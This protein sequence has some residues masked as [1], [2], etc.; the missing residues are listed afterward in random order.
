MHVVVILS[1]QFEEVL[2]K[3]FD[4]SEYFCHNLRFL[5][6]SKFLAEFLTDF[7]IKLIIETSVFRYVH[8]IYQ[9]LKVSNIFKKIIL[10]SH[11]SKS[12]TYLCTVFISLTVSIQGE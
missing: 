1:S 8:Y 6:V 4:P 11:Q 2:Y 3:F 10:R 7:K 5:F 12:A 9:C